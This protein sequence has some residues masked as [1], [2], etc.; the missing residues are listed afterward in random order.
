MQDLG[1]RGHK[2]FV[3][4]QAVRAFSAQSFDSAVVVA[5]VRLVILPYRHIAYF[6]ECCPLKSVQISSKISIYQEME[7]YAP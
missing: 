1:Q 3:N 7:E 4:L 5:E 2:I 6:C